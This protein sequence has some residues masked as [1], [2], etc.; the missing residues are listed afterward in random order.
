MNIN[1]HLIAEA[2]DNLVRIQA[3][4]VAYKAA[5]W[6]V[7]SRLKDT[8]NEDTAEQYGDMMCQYLNLDGMRSCVS[9]IK[10]IKADIARWTQETKEWTAA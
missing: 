7:S 8:H 1:D 9:C 6:I 2:Q 5:Y 3:E 4:L 10:S